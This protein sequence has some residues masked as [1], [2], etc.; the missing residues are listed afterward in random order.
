MPLFFKLT[1]GRDDGY[2]GLLVSSG[3][4]NK[5]CCFI[6][7]PLSWLVGDCH[8]AVC[9]TSH[10]TFLEGTDCIVSGHHP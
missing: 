6:L 5:I 8:P 10:V 3:C 9:K 2:Q 1:G 4:H 7:R